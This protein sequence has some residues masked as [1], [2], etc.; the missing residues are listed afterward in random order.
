MS[1]EVWHCEDILCTSI[2]PSSFL[3]LTVVQFVRFVS[4]VMTIRENRLNC[5]DGSWCWGCN[6]SVYHYT[7]PPL[8]SCM[9]NLL[10]KQKITHC[11]VLLNP[12]EAWLVLLLQAL[13][14]TAAGVPDVFVFVYLIEDYSFSYVIVSDRIL[15]LL[16]FEIYKKK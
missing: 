11:H 1:V 8:Q 16:Q 10:Q 3:H 7:A 14:R 4:A 13:H 9:L 15:K 2:F 5:K 12:W 6:T